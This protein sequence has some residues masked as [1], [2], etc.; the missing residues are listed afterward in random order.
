MA[1]HYLFI[2][3]LLVFIVISIPV[4]IQAQK[5]CFQHGSTLTQGN[6]ESNGCYFDTYLHKCFYSMGQIQTYYPCIHWSGQTTAIY[7]RTEACYHHWCTINSALTTST[8][9][10]CQDPPLL[11][12]EY[13]KVYWQKELKESFMVKHEKQDIGSMNN[14]YVLNYKDVHLITEDIWN[15]YMFIDLDH[16]TLSSYEDP[17]QSINIVL[18]PITFSFVYDTD[19]IKAFTYRLT[20]MYWYRS[21]PPAQAGLKRGL[22]LSVSLSSESS[23]T[24]YQVS[25]LFAIPGTEPNELKKSSNLAGAST[26]SGRDTIIIVDG[27]TA[28]IV[29]TDLAAEQSWGFL[30][31]WIFIFALVG[32]MIAL[33]AEPYDPSLDQRARQQYTRCSVNQPSPPNMYKE[34][35]E[36]AER[37]QKHKKHSKHHKHSASSSESSN[38]SNSE[39]DRP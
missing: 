29:D 5:N 38:N 36:Y 28:T 30:W 32:L 15:N 19:S 7:N 37:H 27:S 1:R 3:L 13:G 2:L 18:D 35:Q 8:H 24:R 23:F 4:Y 11:V 20:F 12:N 16:I 6:C 10:E 21:L 14:V 26:S 22:Q 33:Y 25:V 17:S 39:S 31:F 9:I 34:D